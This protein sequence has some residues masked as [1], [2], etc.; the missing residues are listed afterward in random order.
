MF[1]HQTHTNKMKKKII[2]FFV[3]VSLIIS[4]SC[5]S[6][7]ENQQ[8]FKHPKDMVWT[9]DTITY[10]GSTQI[11]MRSI[12]VIS[13]NDVWVVGHN[14]RSKGQVWHF[15]G[16]KWSEIN[17]LENF[18]RSPHSYSKISAITKN[19]IWFVGDR[20]YSDPNELYG[21]RFEDLI[22]QY[23][24]GFWIEHNLNTS[25]AILSIHCL[26]SNEIW[27]CG[28]NGFV[29]KYNGWNWEKDTI[30]L[31]FPNSGAYLLKSIAKHN[32]RINILANY[33]SST[34]TKHYYIQGNMDNWTVVDTN[35]IDYNNRK[36]N[37]GELGLH[38]GGANKLYSYGSGGVWQWNNEWK[39]V[40]DN[41]MQIRGLMALNENYK[42]ACGV[43]SNVYFYDG[44]QWSVIEALKK[45]DENAVY[46]D[47]W[48]NGNE[49][50]I[51]GNLID[52]YPQKTIVWH[53]K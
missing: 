34:A 11:L 2:F 52:S 15:D 14:D 50:F 28:Y 12:L 31:N 7:T 41:Y 45:V 26:S 16:I 27:V 8:Q 21:N 36:L 37:W 47:A 6:P 46:V 13:P 38:V 33:Y 17:P 1:N 18:Y 3:I 35:G 39:I 30:K 49:I 20:I 53:G 48:T 19:D 9:A 5:N 40:L 32:D 24:N 51:V 10:P 43:N 23:K 44:I 29:A 4:N 25:F 22:I 42:L